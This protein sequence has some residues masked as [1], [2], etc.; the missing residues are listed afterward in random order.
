[1]PC[2]GS[3]L[4]GAKPQREDASLVRAQD[5]GLAAGPSDLRGSTGIFPGPSPGRRASSRP[6]RCK[7][8]ERPGNPGVLSPGSQ[9]RPGPRYRG[10]IPR[11]R[12]TTGGATLITLGTFTK[13][14]T[15]FQ[16]SI[17]RRDFAGGI[18][19]VPAG[20]STAGA[21]MYRVYADGAPVGSAWQARDARG[22][23]YLF[24]HLAGIG[25]AG[26]ITCRL[27][28]DRGGFHALLGLA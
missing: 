6:L 18:D 19:I 10:R 27:V 8:P 15:A 5:D 7:I 16:G 4:R 1:M 25:E 17:L 24:V 28:L 11:L 3:R 13:T 12:T 23:D 22:R 9:R 21:G 2:R 20:G 26:P 14:G